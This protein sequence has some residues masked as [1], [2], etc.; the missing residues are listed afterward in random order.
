MNWINRGICLM[1]LLM[2]AFTIT[3]CAT[4][5]SAPIRPVMKDGYTLGAGDSLR[6]IVYG[7]E[8]LSGEYKVDP[9]G[10]VAFPLISSVNAQGLTVLQLEQEITSQLSPKYLKDPRVSVEVLEYRSVYI[11]GEVR[12]PGKYPYVP[13]MTVMQAVAVAGG[14][15]YRGDES[16][17][18]ITRLDNDTLKTFTIKSNDMIMPGDTLVIKRRWF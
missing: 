11:L 16:S 9:S 10:R 3:A 14:H 17:A 1:A 2:A 13:N 12:V 7:Q 4:N 5:M 18:E 6:I 15:T 8:E